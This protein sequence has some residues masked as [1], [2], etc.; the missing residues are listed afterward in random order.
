[1]PVGVLRAVQRPT[2]DDLM[3]KQI[4]DAIAAEGEGDLARDLPRR[5]HLDRRVAYASVP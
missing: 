4:E 5:R 1:M 3:A 2:Y